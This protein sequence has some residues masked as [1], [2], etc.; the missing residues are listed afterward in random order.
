MTNEE[1][2]AKFLQKTFYCLTLTWKVMAPL[3]KSLLSNNT[4][5]SFENICLGFI[6]HQVFASKFA[7]AAIN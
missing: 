1:Q 2:F 5:K 7:V 3:N 6:S 4:S